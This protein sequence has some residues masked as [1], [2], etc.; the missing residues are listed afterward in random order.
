MGYE[1]SVHPREEDLVVGLDKGSDQLVVYD[2]EAEEPGVEVALALLKEEGHAELVLRNDLM[3]THIYVCSPEV[4]VAFSDHW[5][6][7]DM[8]RYI[9]N[10][11]QNRE[12]GNGRFAYVTGPHEYAARVHDPHVYHAVSLDLL[13]RWLYPN[14]P[15]NNNIHSGDHTTYRC[16][17]ACWDV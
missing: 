8:P 7:Q 9:R 12:M 15:E 2:D 6:Y 4:L 16:V 11:V 10:E 13:H 17:F 1:A 14:V 3:D 5:D